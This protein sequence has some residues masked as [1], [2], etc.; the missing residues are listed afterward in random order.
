MSFLVS[1]VK[2]FERDSSCYSMKFDGPLRSLQLAGSI[3]GGIR[4]NYTG[5]E[6]EALPPIFTHARAERAP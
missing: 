6:A 4:K 1:G 3:P 2:I 5:I